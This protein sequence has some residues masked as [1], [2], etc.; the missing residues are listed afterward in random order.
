MG[1]CSRVWVTLVR[2]Y[3]RTPRTAVVRGSSPHKYIS[4]SWIM[5]SAPAPRQVPTR[6]LLVL[7][8]HATVPCLY[9]TLYAQTGLGLSWPA[10]RSKFDG[11]KYPFS[12]VLESTVLAGN[13]LDIFVAVLSLRCLLLQ[14]CTP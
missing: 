5:V 2:W 10:S 3:R 13:L 9:S 8:G 11:R 14:L 4:H 6:G 7:V 12:A 1:N